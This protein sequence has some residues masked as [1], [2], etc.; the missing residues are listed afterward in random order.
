M[1]KKRITEEEF[2]RRCVNK[3]FELVGET[4]MDFD[5]LREVLKST[6]K[7]YK[8]QDDEKWRFKSNDDYEEWKKFVKEQIVLLKGKVSKKALDDM[9]SWFALDYAF[10]CDE[11]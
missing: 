1:R 3:E 2:F 5:K 8:W 4:E 6:P 11:D 10:F 7:E 9:F